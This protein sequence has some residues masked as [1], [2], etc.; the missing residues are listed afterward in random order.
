M[1]VPT[2]ITHAAYE[3]A[4]ERGVCVAGFGELLDALSLDDD[5]SQHIDSRESYERRRLVRN[6]AV[7][8]LKRK[9]HHAYEVRRKRLRP[10]VIITTDEY[11]FTVDRLYNL[12]DSYDGVAV[13][14][15]VIANPSCYGLSTDSRKAAEW[16]GVSLALF[17]DFLDRVGTNWT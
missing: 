12:L 14:V 10:L 8:S 17:G 15:I 2:R 5:I 1:V 3:R 7:T 11:E 6:K 16:A 9:G 13:D 4:E